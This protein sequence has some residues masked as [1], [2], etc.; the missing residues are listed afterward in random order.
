MACVSSSTI[1][2]IMSESYKLLMSSSFQI[3]LKKLQ[4]SEG[5]INLRTEVM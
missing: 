5:A 3:D 1:F 2:K 4:E